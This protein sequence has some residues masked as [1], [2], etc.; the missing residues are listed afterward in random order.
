MS[1]E[2]GDGAGVLPVRPFTEVSTLPRNFGRLGPEGL[3]S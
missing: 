1:V 2:G 3:E